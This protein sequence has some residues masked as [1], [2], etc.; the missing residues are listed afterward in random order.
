MNP[1]VE[2]VLK[3]PRYQR[4][5]MLMGTLAIIVGLFVWLMFLPK[6]EEYANL[7]RRSADL[8]VKLNSDRRIAANLPTFKAEYEKMLAQ[9]DQALTE[10]PNGREIPKLLTSISSRAKGSGLDV[11]SFRP[12]SEVPKGFYAEVPVKL[13]VEGTFHQIANFFYAVSKLP[14]IVNINEVKIGSKTSQNAGSNVLSVDCLATTFRF[15][16]NTPNQAGTGG[17]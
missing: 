6:Q 3:R 13:K 8:Q 12:G 1:R 14:R 4:V 17:R 5:L 7:L 16:E 2:W 9:L 10:L 11:L 15:L